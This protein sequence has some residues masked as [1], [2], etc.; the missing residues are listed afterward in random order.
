M[1]R[2]RHV[3]VTNISAILHKLSANYGLMYIINF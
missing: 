2:Y 1:Y 3:K